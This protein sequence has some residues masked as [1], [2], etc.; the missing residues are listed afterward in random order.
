M[1]ARARNDASLVRRLGMWI[2]RPFIAALILPVVLEIQGAD[3]VT[4]AV[5]G[6]GGG[7][8]R[9][10]D[11]RMQRSAAHTSPVLRR[12]SGLDADALVDAHRAPLLFPP[13]P[14]PAPL[15][16]APGPDILTLNS[17]AAGGPQLPV[18]NALFF[19]TNALIFAEARGRRGVAVG[20]KM[21]STLDVLLD[22]GGDGVIRVED[23]HSNMSSLFDSCGDLSGAAFDACRVPLQLRRAVSLRYLTPRLRMR[24]CDASAASLSSASSVAIHLRSNEKCCDNP[25]YVQPP[26]ALYET[27]LKQENNGGAFRDAMLLGDSFARELNNRSSPDRSPWANPCLKNLVDSAASS[28]LGSTRVSVGDGE[29]RKDSCALLSSANVVMAASTFTSNLVMLSPRPPKLFVPLPAMGFPFDRCKFWGR[30]DGGES[31][32]ADGKATERFMEEVRQVF[33][34]S[35][36]FQLPIEYLNAAK[37]AAGAEMLMSGVDRKRWAWQRLPGDPSGTSSV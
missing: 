10:N 33:P 3:A 22:F 21:R 6:G 18:G 37:T 12:E 9:E 32:L 2:V 19:L 34:G 8:D 15:A 14:A 30:L 28:A 5:Q 29:L 31:G 4:A 25:M 11:L 17:V 23:G 16:V 35:V 24:S 36:G 26:C 27:I 1:A 20:G 13:S 7:H